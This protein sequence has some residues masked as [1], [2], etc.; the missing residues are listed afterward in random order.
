M[1][2]YRKQIVVRDTPAMVAERIANRKACEQALAD[3]KAKFPV[4]TERNF[5]EA[6]SIQDVRIT[7]LRAAW[8]IR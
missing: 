4:L 3:R 7:E 5:E 1:A 6:A 2:F 8:G